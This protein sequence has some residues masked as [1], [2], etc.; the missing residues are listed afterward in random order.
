MQR[1]RFRADI[2]GLRAIA[3]AAVILFH[4]DVPGFGGGFTGVDVFFVISGFLMTSILFSR[5]DAGRLSVPDFYVERA[6]RILPPL[7]VLVAALLLYG[8]WML[9]PSGLRLLGKHAAGAL[10]FTS[11]I[12]FWLESGYFDPVGR[13]KWLLHTWSLSVEWQFYMLYP[14]LVIAL[15]KFVGRRGTIAALGLLTGASLAVSATL[16][17]TRPTA[18]FFM[19]PPRAWEML[20]GGL[21]CLLPLSERASS[22]QRRAIELVGLALIIVTVLTMADAPWPGWRAAVPVAGTML[23]I[24]A[25]RKGSLLTGNGLLRFLGLRSYSIYLWHWPVVVWLAGEGHTGAA[26]LAAGIALSVGLGWLSHRLIERPSGGALRR[27]AQAGWPARARE[28]A[29]LAAAPAT[30]AAA[31]AGLYLAAGV[32]S[33]FSAAVALADAEQRNSNPALAGCFTAFGVAGPSCL[34]GASNKVAVE[35]IGDSHAAAVASALVAAVPQHAGGVRFQ[36]YAACLTAL[37]TVTDNPESGCDAFNRQMLARLTQGPPSTTP[38]VLVNYWNGYLETKPLHFAVDGATKPSPFTVARFGLAVER[39]LCALSAKRPLWVV[40][41]IPGYHTNVPQAVMRALMKNG[42]ADDIGEPLASVR[43]RSAQANAILDQAALRCG[44]HLLDPT[45]QLCDARLC[46]ASQGG[47]PLYS[48]ESHLSEFGNRRLIPMF[49]RIFMAEPL[50]DPSEPR[51]R[52]T[53]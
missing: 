4:F 14:L 10:T 16:V 48:D 20:A 6:R 35:L 46:Y 13:T 45:P 52:I 11:N 50:S 33:R 51:R 37:G 5:A 24:W 19:L 3:V 26:H 36:G 12:L 15:L 17:E 43:A 47:R 32:P 28:M 1:T 30:I 2:N 40:R 34:L 18:D 7:A 29:L 8:W 23:V 53:K 42:N 49:S 22:H 21:V 25:D 31:G 39:T 41:P 27:T 44:V 38:L 9:P